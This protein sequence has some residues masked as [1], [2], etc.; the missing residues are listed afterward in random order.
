MGSRD[1]CDLYN[2][3]GYGADVFVIRGSLQSKKT[4]Q[5]SASNGIAA[6]KT[7]G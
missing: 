4:N 3:I 2:R 1:V 5:A 7:N 6:N